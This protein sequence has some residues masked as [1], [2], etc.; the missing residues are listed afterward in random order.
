MRHVTDHPQ[1]LRMHYGTPFRLHLVTSLIFG[2]PS[3]LF[4]KTRLFVRSNVYALYVTLNSLAVVKLELSYAC[5]RKFAEV[6][7]V[8]VVTAIDTKS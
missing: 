3:E 4:R 2:F 7:T 6:F 5:S 1:S 8:V